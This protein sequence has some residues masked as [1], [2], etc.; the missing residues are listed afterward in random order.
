M[1]RKVCLFAALLLPLIVNNPLRP[2][3]VNNPKGPAFDCY[4]SFHK[5]LEMTGMFAKDLGITTRC[6]FAANTINSLGEYFTILERLAKEKPS[7]AAAARRLLQIPT[8][9]YTDEQ[10]YSKD[11]QSILQY[12]RRIAAAIQ[13]LQ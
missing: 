3:M 1:F 8:S 2:G 10:H 6:V 5:Q 12:R 4:R 13:K 7:K 11:P 9:I